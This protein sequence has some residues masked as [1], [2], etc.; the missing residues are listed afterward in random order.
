MKKEEREH[1]AH[2]LALEVNGFLKRIYANMKRTVP[3]RPPHITDDMFMLIHAA[4][5]TKTHEFKLNSKE[6]VAQGDIGKVICVTFGLRDPL[7]RKQRALFIASEIYVYHAFA[8]HPDPKYFSKVR[9]QNQYL[10]VVRKW[11]R[12]DN[13]HEL[14]DQAMRYV[15]EEIG[16]HNLAHMQ[17]KGWHVGIT[18]LKKHDHT[19]SDLLGSSEKT[20]KSILK[21]Q[22]RLMDHSMMLKEE[23]L[24]KKEIEDIRFLMDYLEAVIDESPDPKLSS[25]LK[26]L[27]HYIGSL[28][29]IHDNFHKWYV[30]DKKEHDA[31]RKLLKDSPLSADKTRSLLAAESEAETIDLN[32]VY[33][34]F[35]HFEKEKTRI[36]KDLAKVSR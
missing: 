19:I 17:G 15:I 30:E 7:F 35:Q 28:E 14:R 8:N 21:K 34:L 5:F 2:L 6:K 11:F 4:G 12:M 1:Y 31:L 9:C 32:K 16:E 3:L 27:Q 22:H 33:I 10:D 23:H 25:H 36:S 18:R 13:A 26:S 24:I 20:F 29:K